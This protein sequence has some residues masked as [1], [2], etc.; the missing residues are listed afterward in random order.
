M[1]GFAM[2]IIVYV[3]IGLTLYTLICVGRLSL[4]IIS[5]DTGEPLDKDSDVYEWLKMVYCA[6]WIVPAVVGIFGKIFHKEEKN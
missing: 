4:D 5:K 1:L 2:S 3:A 6:G